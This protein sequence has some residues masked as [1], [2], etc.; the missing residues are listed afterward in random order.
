MTFKAPLIKIK[1]DFEIRIPST[2]DAF[3]LAR[4]IA[5]NRN[6]L[7]RWLPW[8]EMS[9]DASDSLVF[10]NKTQDEWTLRRLYTGLIYQK[11]EIIGAVGFHSHV[12]KHMAMGYWVSESCAKKNLCTLASQALISWAF[13][14]YDELYLIELRAATE[15][16]A[17]RRVA[18]KLG[19]KLEGTLRCREWL[20]TQFVDHSVYSVTRPEWKKFTA[21]KRS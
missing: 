9:K 21:A 17:S 13:K 15:N 2:E 16:L 6:Y 5:E 14:F 10:I 3:Q 8:L 7:K 4:V 1:D 11:N 18:E 19:F 20:Y 12:H